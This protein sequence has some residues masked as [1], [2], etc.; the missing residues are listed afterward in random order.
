MNNQDK[1][2]IFEAY[3][4]CIVKENMHNRGP[5][6]VKDILKM[7]ENVNPEMN[8]RFE[9]QIDSHRSTSVCNNAD[10]RIDVEGDEVVV[11]MSG[12]ETDSE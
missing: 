5:M 6:K 11:S 3:T 12:D 8:I 1:Q 9:T 2:N 4:S 10:I 7:F